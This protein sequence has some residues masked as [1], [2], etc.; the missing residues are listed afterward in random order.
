MSLKTPTPTTITKFNGENYPR[1]HDSI[2]AR[3]GAIGCAKAYPYKGGVIKGE[4]KEKN[5]ELREAHERAAR[6][7]LTLKGI[8]RNTSDEKLVNELI[9]MQMEDERALAYV[10]LIE[11]IQ[12]KYQQYAS[13]SDSDPGLL[14]EKMQERWDKRTPFS[15]YRMK[16]KFYHSEMKPQ[17]NPEAYVKRVCDLVRRLDDAGV[18]VDEHAKTTVFLDG[19]TPEYNTIVEVLTAGDTLPTI[20]EAIERIL[21]QADR[22]V[23]SQPTTTEEGLAASTR[24]SLIKC[25][26]CNK[27]GH[28]KSECRSRKS[29]PKCKHCDR[30]NH[31]EENCYKIVPCSKCGK[32]GHGANWCRSAD[33][34]TESGNLAIAV[35]ECLYAT[36]TKK[37]TW[38]LDSGCT[39]HFA[40]GKK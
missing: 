17:E 9:G 16:K 33:K 25:Y 40:N 30:N 4:I 6:L 39:R 27:K 24:L 2:I 14:M 7:R 13:N 20:D 29:Y 28:K 34:K 23:T 37:Q 5:E 31:L 35:E 38:A 19:L 3:L 18:G 32:H 8:L 1:W 15:I 36:K 21:Q 11:S 12:T 10:T 22:K 26:N